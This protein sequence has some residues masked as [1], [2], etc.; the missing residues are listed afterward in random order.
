MPQ[1]LQAGHTG[2]IQ[3][4]QPAKHGSALLRERAEKKEDKHR[5]RANSAWSL[6]SRPGETVTAARSV[7]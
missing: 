7:K 5:G 3:C 2:C 6:G 4:V 1:D